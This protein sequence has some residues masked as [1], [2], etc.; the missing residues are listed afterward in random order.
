MLTKSE[1]LR[2]LRIIVNIGN[3]CKDFGSHGENVDEENVDT[4]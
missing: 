1:K 2:I 3:L 4:E